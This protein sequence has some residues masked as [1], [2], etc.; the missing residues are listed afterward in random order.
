MPLPPFMLI[1]EIVVEPYVGN[2]AYGP[3]YDGP[4]TVKCQLNRRRRV[5]PGNDGKD[6]VS[7]ITMYA[8]PEHENDL[9]PQS[10][11][12]VDGRKATIVEVRPHR[13]LVGVEQ[14]EAVIG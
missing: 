6:V 3:R 7:D 11:V 12:T 5:V 2:T 4:V 1:D 10:R 14:L 8:N 9:R 13:G